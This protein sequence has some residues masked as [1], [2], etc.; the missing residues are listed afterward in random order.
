MVHNSHTLP[1]AL[2]EGLRRLA[3]G[4]YQ[5][6][7]SDAI[8]MI[9]VSVSDATPYCLLGVI[10]LEHDNVAKAIELFSKAASLE[11]SRDLHHAFHG[12]ALVMA[13]RQVQAKEA[14]DRAAA[15]PRSGP[16]AS[17]TIGVV[18]SRTG[19]HE[20]AAPHFEH[21]TQTPNAPANAYYNLGASLQFVGAFDRAETAYLA[22]IERAP[23]FARAYSSLV[24]LKR[25]T[26]DD[27]HLPALKALFEQEEEDPDAALH[28]GHA[29]AKTL[30][31]LGRYEESLEWLGRA[32][33]GKRA[34]IAYDRANDAALF[35]AARATVD[36]ARDDPTD[37]EA[38]GPIFIIGMPRTG[39]TLIDRI[40]SSHA[41]VVSAGELNTFAGLIKEAAG[42][43]SNLV[44]DVDTLS[45]VDE[46][47]LEAIGATYLERTRAL[48]RGAPRFTDK[49]PLNFFYAGLILRALPN[50]R[51]IALRRGAMDTCLSNYRQ[52]FSTGYSYYN[53]SLD[54][55]DAAAYFAEFDQ[56]MT[57][58]SSVLPAS[59]FAEFSYESIVEDQEEQTRRLLAFCGLEWQERCL[60]FHENA[61]PVSTASSVQVR[62]PLYSGSIGRWRRYGGALGGV[63]DQLEALGA[64]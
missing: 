62:Q 51:I 41:D 33:R 36:H 59:R 30:E 18:Y 19:F 35:A 61:A 63:K 42:T 46:V 1:A 53:Y 13:G 12:K 57:H 29:I 14:A 20:L 60:R 54:L 38:A 4:A 27:N 52:L 17:D 15:L 26:V 23:Q 40:V 2:I 21:L 3:A 50:A 9:R 10:A 7:H 31:D 32:K 37:A 6:V 39:T 22:A 45:A 34:A 11:P 16:A 24:N 56:L 49:M 47:E 44:L 25:Q 55:G 5:E 43:P 8:A 48:A 64:V 28:L 58:W